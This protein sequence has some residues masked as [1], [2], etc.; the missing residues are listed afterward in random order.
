MAQALY[1]QYRSKRF[2][3]VVGQEHI[4]DLLSEAISKNAFSH[5][6]LFTGPRGVGK[7]S[8]ARILAHEINQLEYSEVTHLDIIEIDAASNR[9]IDDIRDLREKVHITPSSAKYKVYIIDEVHMLTGESFNALLKTLE[10]PPAHVVFILATTELHKVPATIA[11]RTQRFAFRPITKSKVVEHLR[12]IA[13]NEKINIEDSALE[14]IADHGEGSF[15]DSISLLDQLSSLKNSSIA[16]SDVEMLLGLAPADLLRNLIEQVSLKHPDDS[17]KILKDLFDRGYSVSA[18]TSQLLHMIPKLAD[19]HP[20]LYDF[21][22]ELLEVPKSYSPQIKLLTVIAR[23]AYKPKVPRSM[24]LSAISNTS[25][26]APIIKKTNTKKASIPPES[27]DSNIRSTKATETEI[28]DWELVLK[29]IQKRNSALYSVLRRA[30][31]SQENETLTLEFVYNLHRKKLDDSKY[32]SQLI[33]LITNVYGNCPK[34]VVTVKGAT[35]IASHPL[36]V[37]VAGIMGGGE[38]VNA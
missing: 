12:T 7:T 28:I 23:A 10:E 5:A 37:T 30:N 8:V 35:Q 26:S 32:R 34:I 6:Y 9:R 3:E 16:V 22:H 29:K 14:L 15:R 13:A 38:Q 17:V 21:M 25:I 18:I 33:S 19:E 20:Q 11:S 36:V 31:A 27:I 4:T 1:R 2:S 24:P